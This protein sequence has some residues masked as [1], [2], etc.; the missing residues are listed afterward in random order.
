MLRQLASPV[1]PLALVCCDHQEENKLESVNA[2]EPW[3]SVSVQ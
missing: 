1:F 3:E 2:N